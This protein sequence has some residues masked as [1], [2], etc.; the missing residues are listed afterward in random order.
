MKILK[1]LLLL[2]LTTGAV[3]AQTLP[4]DLFI[5]GYVSDPNGIAQEGI[6]ICVD[7]SN[8][9]TFPLDSICTTT[10]ANGW[11][12]LTIP[13]GSV[14]GPNIDFTLILDDPCPFMQTYQTATVSNQQGIV[15]FVTLDWE[16]CAPNNNA[17][18]VSFTSTND[19]LNGTWTFVASATGTAP[20]I[21][22]WWV[23]GTSYSTQTVTHAFNGGTVGVYVTVTDANGCEAMYGD[24]LYLNGPSACFAYLQAS[25]NPILGTTL[26][27]VATGGTP[28]YSYIW[29]PSGDVTSSILATDPGVYCCVITDSNGCT[30]TTCDTVPDP[31]PGCSVE[32]YTSWDTT[33]TGDVIYF[34]STSGNWASYAWSDGST[35]STTTVENVS[36]NG[37]VICVTVTDANGCVATACDQLLPI[38][39]SGCQAG[40]SYQSGP[41]NQLL[42]GDTVQLFFDGV[43]SLQSD[44]LWT[45]TVDQFVFTATGMNPIF[46]LPPTLIPI[47]GIAVEICV[48]VTDNANNCTDTYCQT[49]LAVPN[50]NTNNCDANY[51]WV[52][53]SMLGAPLP[54]VQFTDLSSEDAT[55]WYWDFGDGA[56][57]TDQ[58]PLHLYNGNGPFVVCLTIVTPN[59]QCQSTFCDTVYVGTNPGNCDASFSNSGETPIGYTFSANVQDPNLFYYWEI[60]NIFVGDGYDAYAPGFT[61]GTHTVCLTIIDSLVG[62]SDTQCLTIT[63]GSPNCYGYVSGQAYAGSNNQPLFDGV[64]YLITFDANSNQL[65]VVDSIVL[66]TSNSFFFGALPCGDYLVKAAAYSGSPY[67]S[68]HIPTYHGNSPFWGFAQ[69]LTIG[70]PNQIVTADVTLIAASNPGGPGFIGGDVTEGANKTDPGDV[71]SGMQ[72]MIFNLSGDAIAYTYTDGNGEFG[73]SNLAYGTYQVYVEALGVQTIPAVVTIGPDSPSEEGV[74]IFASESLISTGIEEFDFDGAISEVYPNPV[75]NQASIKLNLDAALMINVS[76]VDLTGRTISS[77]TI[78]AAGGENTINVSAD[79]LKNGYYFLNIQDVDNNFSVTRKFMRID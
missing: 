57:S 6:L 28:P 38:N 63:I 4:D 53:D 2:L 14:F 21:Y 52:I 5:S 48:T 15:D 3:L 50:N 75:A 17:C 71:L 47:N 76:V 59:P 25:T 7:G 55:Y 43:A 35:G 23:D 33:I 12:S 37:E 22:D 73:F 64:V 11:Y 51:S 27:V 69:A 34:C 19:S 18:N 56:T 42:V 78:S 66:D 24:T 58:N 62:C 20:F 77:Q 45:I 29:Q 60:D 49:V 68:N 39:P 79:E 74:H 41:N 70:Q 8:T 54:G 30:F 72:V 67:Y 31:N 9:P 44:Y 36:P 16:L 32:V 65:T 40:F 10:D 46:A 26:E 61:N 13:N 1:T